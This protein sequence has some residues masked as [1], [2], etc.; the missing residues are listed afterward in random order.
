MI[1]TVTRTSKTVDGIFGN[2]VLDDDPFKCVTEENLAL[3]IPPGAYDVVFMWS[4]HFQQIMPHVIVPNRTAIEV[5]WANFPKQL[6][7]CLSLGTEQDMKDDMITESKD[8]WINFIKAISD[9]FSLKLKIIED[10]G[11]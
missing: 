1:I 11:T 9:Q 3:C 5:H 10:F 2:L 8:A 6:E 4:D 7:G